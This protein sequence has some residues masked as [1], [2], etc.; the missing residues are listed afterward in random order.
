MAKSEKKGIGTWTLRRKMAAVLTAAVTVSIAATVVIQAFNMKRN[1]FDQ[2][3]TAN[4]HITELLG[5]QISGGLRWKKAAAIERAYKSFAADRTTNLASLIVFDATGKA[6][7]HHDSNELPSYDLSQTTTENSEALA[8]GETVAT[9]TDTH[10]VV[11][12]PVTA[13][14]DKARVGTLAVAWSLENVN[15]N[16]SVNIREAFI[17]SFVMLIV[18]MVVLLFLVNRMITKPLTTLTSAMGS[19]ADDDLQVEVPALERGDEIGLMG[20]ALQVFK[21]HAIER[22]EMKKEQEEAE[23]RA[24]EDRRKAMNDL[25]DTFESSVKGVVDTV[26]SASTEMQAT[27]QSMAETADKATRQAGAAAAGVEQASANVQTVASAA[28][29]LSASIKEIAQQVDKATD[30]S[31]EAVETTRR[32]NATVKTLADGAQ[33]I[34]EVVNLINDIASQTNLLALN[35]T[36]EAARA[37]DAGKG[38]AVVASEVKALAS[39]TAKATEEIAS[40]ISSMQTVTEDT[41]TAIEEIREVIGKMGEIATTIASAVEEQGAATQEIARNAQEAAKDTT[42]VSGNVSGVTEAAAEAGT[43]SAQMLQ[44]AGGLSE[45]S[46]LLRAEVD[47]FLAQVRAG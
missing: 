12:T 46:E 33:K 34:G 25:A 44:A 41:V 32:T 5:I 43:A 26:A 45:Q 19:L 36:I 10:I 4:T 27:A 13:G 42:D 7:T 47:K 16:V 23:R 22:E 11:V 39:Q 24:Q 38:F 35:A 3:V 28:E 2:A 8:R 20:R 6:F 29:E 18:S 14:K 40:Q 1:L 21:D 30:T 31:Q 9:L 37:G 17:I 15:Q